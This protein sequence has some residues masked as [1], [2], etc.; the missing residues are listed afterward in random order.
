VVEIAAAIGWVVL[1]CL[2]WFGLLRIS[3]ER[4]VTKVFWIIFKHEYISMVSMGLEGL[5]GG[6]MPRGRGGFSEPNWVGWGNS[7][8]ILLV[9]TFVIKT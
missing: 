1:M 8:E 4:D 3:A 6:K 7:G 5:V 9:D 2:P